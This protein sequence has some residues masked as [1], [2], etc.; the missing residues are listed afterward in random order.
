MTNFNATV[1]SIVN[2]RTKLNLNKKSKE[3]NAQTLKKEQD[4]KEYANFNQAD[5]LVPLTRRVQ[6]I[7]T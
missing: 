2:K 5:K 3:K 7:A 4:K 6:Q 1:P